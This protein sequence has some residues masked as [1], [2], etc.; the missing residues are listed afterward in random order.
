MEV[1]ER[2]QS[3]PSIS[4]TY[5][6]ALLR[7]PLKHHGRSK[8]GERKLDAC[9]GWASSRARD[10]AGPYGRPQRVVAFFATLQRN[11]Q[12]PA[13]EKAL[14]ANEFQDLTL[15]EPAPGARGRPA[16]FVQLWWMVDALLVRPT[17]QA[18]F[19]WRRFVLRR[20]GAQI[21]SNVKI[22]PGVRV[23]YPWKLKVGDNCWIGDDATLYTIDEISLGDHVVISQGA[24]LCAGTHDARDI[25]FPVV[26]GSISIG[27]ETWIATRAF[28]GPGIRV[29]R[30]AVVGACSVV[31]SDVPPATIYAGFPARAVRTRKVRRRPDS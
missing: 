7:E 27:S 6:F 19:A 16:W 25:S 10:G 29:G 17:P 12:P 1:T 26:A 13:R 4:A 9:S 28:I 5:V 22:R 21:G 3:T 8:L 14:T 15:F 24:Y 30:G 23:T 20:F 2:R 11:S 18:L 31:Q